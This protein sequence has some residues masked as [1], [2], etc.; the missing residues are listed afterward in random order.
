M[1]LTYRTASILTFA[2]G[3]LLTG[4]GDKAIGYPGTA[5]SLV[6]SA[7][8]APQGTNILF[9]AMVSPAVGNGTVSF[10]DGATVLGSGVV[11]AGQASFSTASLPVGD[12]SLVAEFTG[13]YAEAPS[14]SSPVPLD[15]TA[16]P[17]AG[18]TTTLTAS[19]NSLTLGLPFNLKASVVSSLATGT[20]NFYDGNTLVGSSLPLNSSGTA[21]LYGT[22]DAP[23][24]REF[25]AIYSGALGYA[26]S[27]SNE[28]EV[29][30]SA[31]PPIP[32]TLI[33]SLSPLTV[34]A[35]QLATVTINLLPLAAQG[36]VALIVNG[37][38]VSI[39]SSPLVPL[40]HGIHSGNGLST[41]RPDSSSTGSI[42]SK[43]GGTYTDSFS[44]GQH[45]FYAVFTGEVPYLSSTSNL[46]TLTVTP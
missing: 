19:T 25:T 5:T 1:C 41:Y 42:G 24:V 12:H 37:K 22:I 2:L 36:S 43:L 45:T 46:V 31:G 14:T 6:L 18:T 23:G 30:V 40:V 20:V 15:I 44:V 16:V 13:T 9:S 33:L 21:T 11:I 27:T 35:G 4:C 29:N 32:T 17:Q 7:R 34:Q 39:D 26:P 3:T 8:E 10:R 38:T 28:V